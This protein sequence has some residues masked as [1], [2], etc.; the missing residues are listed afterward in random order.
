[1]RGIAALF[2]LVAP[3]P[4][5]AVPDRRRRADIPRLPPGR[6]R[7][8]GLRNRRRLAENDARIPGQGSRNAVGLSPHRQGVPERQQNLRAVA[9][10]TVYEADPSA[11][12]VV[13]VVCYPVAPVAHEV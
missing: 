4:C 1:M 11:R 9:L 3:P 13:G 7:R 12:R 10:R 2:A 8:L 6:P 5:T